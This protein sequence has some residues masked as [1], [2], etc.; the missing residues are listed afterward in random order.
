M[1]SACRD[2]GRRRHDGE[3]LLC[4]FLADVVDVSVERPANW[5]DGN[6]RCIHAGLATG[7][8]SGLAELSRTWSASKRFVPEMD[9]ELRSGLVAGW[10]EAVRRTIGKVQR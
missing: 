6:R 10:K 1:R 5:N 2:P 8:W 7:V 4:Q 9:V 3:Q